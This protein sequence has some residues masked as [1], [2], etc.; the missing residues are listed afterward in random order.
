M[1]KEHDVRIDRSKLHPWMDYKLTCLLREC[2]KKGIYLIVTEGSGQRNSRMP[3]MQ[4]DGLNRGRSLL[5]PK[6]ATIPANTC[7]GL[8]LILQSTIPRNYMIPI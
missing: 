7:G 4:R 3:C 5:M 1:K 6:A 8:L 2:G